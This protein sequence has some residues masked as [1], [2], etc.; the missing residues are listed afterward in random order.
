MNHSFDVEHAKTYGVE[1]AILIHSFQ[2]WLEKNRANGRHIHDGRA[3]TYNSVR[4]FERLFSYWTPKQIRRILDS[5]ETQG[6]VITGHWGSDEGRDPLDRTLWY[7][8]YDESTFLPT[9]Q[10]TLGGE[11]DD[12][13]KRANASDPKGKSSTATICPNGQMH[14]AKRANESKEQLSTGTVRNVHVETA[15]AAA[16]PPRTRAH[17]GPPLQT[18]AAAVASHSPDT[19][20]D[21][22]ALPYTLTPEEIAFRDA[23]R[24][25]HVERA[26]AQLLALGCDNEFDAERYA[27]RHAWFI[28]DYLD[29]ARRLPLKNRFGW[30]R[31]RL[32]ELAA[33]QER[34]RHGSR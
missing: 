20:P 3:W 9:S 4:A 30:I 14:V 1:E 2:F 8:F 15:A 18:A 7:A 24:E 5:L 29:Q 27:R 19:E 31:K 28:N 32:D 13:P 17:E 25:A 21:T 22:Y 11:L 12:L 26:T 16:V 6:V 10:P 34:A 33:E 23:A